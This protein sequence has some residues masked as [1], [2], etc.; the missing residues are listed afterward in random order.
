MHIP[1]TLGEA[2]EYFAHRGWRLQF[3]RVEGSVVPDLVRVESGDVIAGYGGGPT[4]TT[5]EQAACRAAHRYIV[6]ED[7]PPPLPRRL[8]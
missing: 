7:P 4:T 1:T 2:T 5:E 3:R 6:E 8:P